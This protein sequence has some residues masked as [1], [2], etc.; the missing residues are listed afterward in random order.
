MDFLSSKYPSK[1]IHF[2]Q[3]R[4]NTG[5]FG[6][7]FIGGGRSSKSR[8]VSAVQRNFQSLVSSGIYSRLKI[9]M[10]RNMWIRRKPV[11]NDT[12]PPVVPLTTGGAIITIFM[13]S[14][15]LVGLAL[16]LFLIEGHKYEIKK[17][18]RSWATRCIKLRANLCQRKGLEQIEK[19]KLKADRIQVKSRR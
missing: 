10:A 2:G 9:E 14:G 8:G 6:W 4:L 16:I 13:L 3:D 17:V 18:V 5:R 19:G 7:W 12:A 11:E 15:V 1:K